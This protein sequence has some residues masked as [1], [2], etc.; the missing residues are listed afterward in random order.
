MK[1]EQIQARWHDY[2]DQIKQRWSGLTDDDLTVAGG[3][4][5]WLAAKI[6][7]RSGA[8][9]SQVEKEIAEFEIECKCAT[10]AAGTP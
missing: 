2:K 6:Q 8:A 9:G 5:D 7:L 10:P 4:R 3:R 1:W